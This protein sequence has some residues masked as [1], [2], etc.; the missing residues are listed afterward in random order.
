MLVSWKHL[1]D[2]LEVAILSVEVQISN[3]AGY[4]SFFKIS[5][6]FMLLVIIIYPNY[7]S[8]FFLAIVDDFKIQG[9]QNFLKKCS[10][11][12]F[13]QTTFLSFCYFF[14]NDPIKDTGKFLR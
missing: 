11:R 6:K 12:G 13:F 5:P 14:R 2:T 3:S 1:R 8:F 7:H 10:L 9:R 4:I